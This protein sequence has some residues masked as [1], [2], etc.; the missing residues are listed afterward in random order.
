[1]QK[2]CPEC[3][4][5]K[6]QQQLSSNKVFAFFQIVT[7]TGLMAVMGGAMLSF[8]GIIIWPLLVISIPMALIGGVLMLIGFI[9]ASIGYLTDKK[10]NYKC[11]GCHLLFQ[12]T[13]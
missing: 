11:S 12:V 9:P 13:K 4:S 8:I 10:M 1:M 2:Q 6:V 5:Y 3:K 7:M